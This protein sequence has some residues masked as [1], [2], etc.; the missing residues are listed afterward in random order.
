MPQ[1]MLFA[2]VGV[3]AVVAYRLIRREMLRVAD[4]LAEV[5]APREIRRGG[6][7]VRDADGIYRPERPQR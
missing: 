5:R 4:T 1:A 3:A 7:L 6:R 2:A